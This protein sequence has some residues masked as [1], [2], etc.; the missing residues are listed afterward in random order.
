MN[1]RIVQI[2]MRSY[3]NANG[4]KAGRPGL[5]RSK[6]FGPDL[7]LEAEPECPGAGTYTW[8]EDGDF[9][10]VGVLVLRCSHEGHE[11]TNFTDW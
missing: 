3:Q 10:D 8:V 9:P 4:F 11:P 7:L 2:E 1:I 5:E 6:I